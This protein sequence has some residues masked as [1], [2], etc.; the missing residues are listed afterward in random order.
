MLLSSDYLRSNLIAV[1]TKGAIVMFVGFTCTSSRSL[2]FNE[3]SLRAA[4]GVGNSGQLHYF[5]FGPAAVFI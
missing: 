1:V 5:L 3:P 2:L 4:Y